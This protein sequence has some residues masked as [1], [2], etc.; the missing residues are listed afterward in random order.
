MI[1]ICRQN[2]ES[3]LEKVRNGKLDAVSLSTSNLVDEIIV[4]MHEKGILSCLSESISDKRA[5]NTFV[6]F[7]ISWA[8][9]IAAKMKIRTSLTDIPFAITDHK[10]L[11]ILG[12]NLLISNDELQKGFMTEGSLRHLI[13]KYK[14]EELFDGYN[15]TVQNYMMPQM[16]LLPDIHILDCTKLEVNWHNTNYESAGIVRNDEGNLVRGYKLATLRGLTD[17]GGVVEEIK[18]GSINEH[19]LSLSKDMILESPV[20][21]NGD[22]LIEDRGFLS[23]DILNRLKTERGVDTFVPLKRNM[24]AYNIA[25]QIAQEEDNWHPHPNKKRKK[26]KIAFVTDLAPYWESDK[27]QEDVPFNACVVW[28]LEAKGE[29]DKFFVFITTNINISAKQIIQ[30]YELRPE[31]EEDYRQL[32]D[33]W[34]L[35]DF[36]STK[37]NII[38]F[39]II[40]VLFGYLFFQLYTMMPQGEQYSQKSLPVVLKN[41]EARALQHIVLYVDDEFGIVTIIELA[42]MYIELNDNVQKILKTV[43]G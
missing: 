11:A 6:P 4:A 10:T 43:L 9:A 30:T 28:N 39:H 2:K 35:E 41:Y 12:Y 33:F 22:L 14:S 19:D 29:Y 8:L 3:V 21:K 16:G 37:L 32:K 7:E 18:F 1:K 5:D 26:Q 25:T 23:R 36:K 15:R 34:K 24:P 13:G 27:P 17:D 40:C 31:I 20:L 38:A 42:E